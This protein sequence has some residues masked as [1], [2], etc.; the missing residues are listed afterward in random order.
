[1]SALNTD[2]STYRGPPREGALRP[3]FPLWMYH[4]V[5]A[6]VIVINSVQEEALIASDS[7]WGIT[8]Y[9]ANTPVTIALAATNNDLLPLG[10]GPTS[11]RQLWAPASG[12]SIVTGLNA[13]GIPDNFSIP[14]RNLSTT[15]SITFLHLS[16]LSMP[17]NQ[18]SCPQ[19]VSAVL[20]PL[21]G[22][23]LTYYVNVWGFE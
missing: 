3:G 4:P 16:S 14:I 21:T 19:G 1:M 18:I 17:A 13:A 8:P 9:P 20:P 15:D 2:A 7:R 5:Y 6:P 22:A 10:F 11:V 12:G 23:W